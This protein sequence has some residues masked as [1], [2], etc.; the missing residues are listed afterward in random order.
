M[1]PASKPLLAL[2]GGLDPVLHMFHQ[3]FPTISMKPHR[4]EGPMPQ[5]LL[6]TMHAVLHNGLGGLEQ[7][8]YRT[9]VPVL[10][11]AAG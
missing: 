1:R 11:P 3:V 5:P 7:L 2:W 9:D 4:R 8:E 10:K 6:E